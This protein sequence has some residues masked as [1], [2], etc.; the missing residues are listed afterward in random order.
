MTGQAEKESNDQN[1]FLS[2]AFLTITCSKFRI[3]LNE[4]ILT[5]STGKAT[6]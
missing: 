6:P 4:W 3:H 1:L 5:M 2:Y